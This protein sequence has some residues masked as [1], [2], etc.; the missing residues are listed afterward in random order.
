MKRVIIIN[1]SKFQIPWLQ[2]L[3]QSQFS[4]FSRAVQL[5]KAASLLQINAASHQNFRQ[6]STSNLRKIAAVVFDMDG[7]L[8]VPCID[9]AEMRRRVGVTD[10]QD[11]LTVI[12]GWPADQRAAAYKAIA[13]VEQEALQNMK[14]MPGAEELCSL[15][16]VAGVPRALVTRNVSSSVD[17][18]HA[19]HFNLPPFFPALSRE[20]TPY[21]PDPAALLHIADHYGAEA[22]EL[23]MIGDSAKDDVVCANR[24]GAVS[25]LLN[26]D[27]MYAESD[28]VGELKPT[29]VVE[30][31]HEVA[32]VLRTQVNLWKTNYATYF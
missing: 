4:M 15:L 13:D 16:D 10:G 2:V 27:N 29:F 5:Q 26:M 8:T 9:F 31:L 28:L 7:T 19:T 23:V 21:K 6:M 24:A 14:V 20:W 18:F 32:E 30:S 1:H 17:F 3:Q 25:I 11:I 12:D 22:T